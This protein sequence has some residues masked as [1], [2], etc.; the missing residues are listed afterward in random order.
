MIGNL[1]TNCKAKQKRDL[2]RLYNSCENPAH[3]DKPLSLE[4]LKDRKLENE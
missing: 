2:A 1:S 4:Q 3:D